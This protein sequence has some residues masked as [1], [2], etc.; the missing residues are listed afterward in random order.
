MRGEYHSAQGNTMRQLPE[1]FLDFL[2]SHNKKKDRARLKH[3]QVQHLYMVAEAKPLIIY[4][5]DLLVYLFDW[6]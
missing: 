6:C 3:L 4:P 5:K 1:K 2:K